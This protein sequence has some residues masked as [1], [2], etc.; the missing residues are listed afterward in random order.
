MRINV[1]EITELETVINS[2][3]K[4]NLD[5]NSHEELREREKEYYR[6]CI[7]NCI[8]KILKLEM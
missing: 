2:I 1:N 4:N 5:I 7:V 3:V 8:D 6:D